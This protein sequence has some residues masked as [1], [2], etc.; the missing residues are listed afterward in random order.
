MKKRIQFDVEEAEV[1]RIDA[2]VK[3]ARH[4]TRAELFRRAIML[5]RL[6]IRADKVIL[7]NDGKRERVIP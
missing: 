1:A 6:A 7:V 3:K 4:T 5:Y 2:D